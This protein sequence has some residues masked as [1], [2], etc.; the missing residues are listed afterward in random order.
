M[1]PEAL[2]L[3]WVLLVLGLGELFFGHE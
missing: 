2:F 3:M 1:S